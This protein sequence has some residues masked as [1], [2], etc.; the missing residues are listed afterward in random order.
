VRASFFC[1]AVVAN[2]APR[3]D[4]PLPSF[5]SD[6]QPALL[7]ERPSLAT[8]P[9]DWPAADLLEDVCGEILRLPV[10]LPAAIAM[11][12]GIAARMARSLASDGPE[13]ARRL[14][15]EYRDREAQLI[16]ASVVRPFDDGY[17]ARLLLAPFLWVAVRR[18]AGRVEH[19][20]AMARLALGRGAHVPVDRETAIELGALP[21]IAF[22][23][24]LDE[25]SR[26]LRRWLLHLLRSRALL[27]EMGVDGAIY[28]LGVAYALARWYARA[29]AL[30]AGRDAVGAAEVLEAIRTVDGYHFGHNYSNGYATRRRLMERGVLWLVQTPATFAGLVLEPGSEALSG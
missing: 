15:E 8:G 5:A 7:P 1:P 28:S 16:L 23:P 24:G 26:P 25:L 17:S 19:S 10:K 29:N 2:D 3:P 20:L 21:S 6:Q 27:V 30:A 14:V 13:R 22:D 9:I 12:G 11:A 18:G 4:D